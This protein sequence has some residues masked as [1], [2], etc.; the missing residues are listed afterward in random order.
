MAMP[1]VAWI[2]VAQQSSTVSPQTQ[3]APSAP[4]DLAQEMQFSDQ[5][6]FSVAGVTDWTAAGGHG[7]DA[8][9]RASESLASATATLTPAPGEAHPSAADAARETRLRSALL[10]TPEGF[11]ENEQLGELLLEQ[12]RFTD[13][14]PLLETAHRLDPASETSLEDLARAEAG[15][16]KLAQARERITS[17]LAQHPGAP[18]LRLAAQLDEQL[19]DP[20]KAVR[21]FEQAATLDPSEQNEFDWASELLSHRAIWQAEAVFRKGA[22]AYPTSV[23]M[24]T[25]LG[26]ALFAG[27]RYDDAA[28]QL[29]KASDL[30]PEDPHPYL[31]LGQ[32]ELAAPNALPCV[33]AK[34]ARFLQM[35]PRSATAHYLYAMAI[36]KAA[37]RSES[38]KQV[39]QLLHEAVSLDGHCS[40]AYL[41]LGNLAAERRDTPAAI[42]FYNKAIAAAPQLAD[43]HYRLGV[44]YDRSGRT[45]D[46]AREFALHD[47]LQQ[48]QAAA[49]EAQRKAVKQF[50]FAGQAEPPLKPIEP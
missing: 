1:F 16:G 43:A 14:M 26:A 19:G 35:Q 7:S 34:L 22:S 32:V 11:A 36:L 27:A 8:T 47:Q 45:A 12:G 24:Q 41:E 28:T 17:S 6:H 50:L 40:E 15:T 30:A 39:E 18:L 21:E 42:D 29:C 31:F 9:L 5:P 44:A 48:Q 20:L 49:V 38:A 10:Q 23:R 37:A 3:A 2:A 25:G 46:A 4:D 13:A 33:E